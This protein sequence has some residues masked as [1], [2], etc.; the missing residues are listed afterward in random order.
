MKIRGLFS[1][2]CGPLPSRAKPSLH[3]LIYL[4]HHRHR[5]RSTAAPLFVFKDGICPIVL[6]PPGHNLT[7][8]RMPP[9][10]SW[11]C[12]SGFHAPRPN[13]RS[14]KFDNLSWYARQFVRCTP[15]YTIEFGVTNRLYSSSKPSCPSG[16]LSGHAPCN[17]D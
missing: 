2:R 5:P 8:V 4:L 10:P 6:L 1:W 16:G 14:H 3:Q 17:W 13:C 7:C 12:L 15:R 9:S 11:R